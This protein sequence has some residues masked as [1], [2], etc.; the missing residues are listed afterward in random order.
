MLDAA[1]L[2]LVF[3]GALGLALWLG[4][5]LRGLWEASSRNSRAAPEPL[6]PDEPDHAPEGESTRV[7]PRVPLDDNTQTPR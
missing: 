7:E 1:V 2:E 4:W 5:A 3:A 6:T